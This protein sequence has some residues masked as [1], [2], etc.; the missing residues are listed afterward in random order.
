MYPTEV[1]Q[2]IKILSREALLITGING[3]VGRGLAAA[4]QE[5][6]RL[7][8]GTEKGGGRRETGGR[9]DGSQVFV[10][11]EIDERTDWGKA[12]DGIDVVVH[13]AARVHVMDDLADDS[14][15]EFRFARHC[16]EFHGVKMITQDEI[17]RS[18]YEEVNS[19]GAGYY[20][21]TN[22]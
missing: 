4:L 14:L 19:Y 1:Q 7:V 5:S 12:L 13:L 11:G 15:A 20:S 3:F 22:C 2:G 9:E 18:E 17:K 8:K 16:R 6:D 21:I 10:S